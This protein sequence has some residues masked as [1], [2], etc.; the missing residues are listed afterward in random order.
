MKFQGG[1]LTRASGG[2]LKTKNPLH[3]ASGERVIAPDIHLPFHGRILAG[4]EL[5]P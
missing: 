1:S 2:M 5:A 4:G 3:L